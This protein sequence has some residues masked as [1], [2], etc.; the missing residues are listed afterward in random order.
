MRAL[1][2]TMIELLVVVSIIAI[3]AALLLPA[4]RLVRGAAQA[5]ACAGNLR[6]IGLGIQT[7]AAEHDGALV[8]A[9][10]KKELTPAAFIADDPATQW[11]GCYWYHQP[12]LGQYLEFATTG[13]QAGSARQVLTCPAATGLKDW[14]GNRITATLGLNALVANACDSEP[15][16]V[17]MLARLS[18]PAARTV[19]AGD[20]FAGSFDPGYGTTPSLYGVVDDDPALSPFTTGTVNSASNWRRRHGR[21]AN[22]LFLDGH[23]DHSATP[24]ADQLAGLSYYTP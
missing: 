19:V 2:F 23:V 6:Q 24:R 18:H 9:R 4:I 11:G 14:L 1:G 15:W 10:I 8:P 17:R 7:Y 5:A 13:T 20:G 21:G 22:W 16:P 3:L 12:L